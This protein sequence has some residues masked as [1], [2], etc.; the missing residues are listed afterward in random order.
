MDIEKIIEKYGLNVDNT[1][2]LH[3]KGLKRSTRI[4]KISKPALGEN[5]YIVDT[6]AGK[7]IACHPYI[8]GKELDRLA[9]SA[10]IEAAK[11]IRHVVLTREA[12]STKS[13]VFE[14]VLRAAPGYKLLPALKA[15]LPGSRI[16][17]A[18]I[19][20]K[21]I[22]KSYRDHATQELKTVYKDFSGIP[23]G[24]RIILF[25][26][27]TEATGA[28]GKLALEEAI[29]ESELKGSTIT[30]VVLYGFMAIPGLRLLKDVA[31][32]HG[33]NMYAFAISNIS[34]LAYNNYDMTLYGTDESYFSKYG[35]VRNLGSIV[36]RKT[37]KR[38]LPEF[39]PGCDQPGDWSSRQERL[40]T[41][42]RYESGG[43]KEHLIRS[44]AL[45]ERLRKIPGYEKWQ[46]ALAQEEL[47]KLRLTLSKYSLPDDDATAVSV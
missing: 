20:P 16:S 3:F 29:K 38:Y 2:Q 13:I 21:Y 23:H 43:T 17:E 14:H 27:D 10:A 11:T 8:V 1:V 40:F 34:E 22:Q 5:T 41:G 47:T 36:D 25:K 7:D 26:P 15:T 35:E 31:D 30:D 37:L 32:R 28:S 33:I 44:M 24:K 18:F 42:R 9:L 12:R 4:F 46:D 45:I 39:I 19:R 6:L